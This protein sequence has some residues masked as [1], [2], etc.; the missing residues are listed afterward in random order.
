MSPSP[1]PDSLVRGVMQGLQGVLDTA[2]GQETVSVPRAWVEH[3]RD[4][5]GVVRKILD[6]PLA[7]TSPVALISVGVVGVF[8]GLAAGWLL[9]H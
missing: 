2:P 9:S 8:V 6:E 5:L 1:T 3:W 7:P 4:T